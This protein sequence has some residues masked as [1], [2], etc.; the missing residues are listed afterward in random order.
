MTAQDGETTQGYTLTISRDPSRDASLADITVA[1]T[2]VVDNGD[3][4][5]TATLDEATT[6]SSVTVTAGNKFATVVI[7]DVRNRRV[8]GEG[9]ARASIT[10]DDPGDGTELRIKITAQ[11]GR[12]DDSADYTLTVNRS[13]STDARLSALELLPQSSVAVEPLVI[14][15]SL[16]DGGEYPASFTDIVTGVRVKP[17]AQP[18]VDKI[19][20]FAPGSDRGEVVAENGQSSLIAVTEGRTT[21]ITIVVTAQDRRTTQDYIVLIT[22]GNIDVDLGAL[23]IISGEN[24]LADFDSLATSTNYVYTIPNPIVGDKITSV[25]LQAQAEHPDATISLTVDDD[26]PPR[27]MG[28]NTI[29]ENIRLDEGETKRARIVVTAQRRSV[30]KTYTVTI[31][32][33]ASRD[34]RL[35]RLA[36]SSSELIP[37]FGFDSSAAT[38]EIRKYSVE[39]PNDAANVNLGAAAANANT[40]LT[41]SE[42]GNSRSGNSVTL[43]IAINPGQHEDIT[44]SATAQDRT[45]A[46][47]TVVISRAASVTRS[48]LG[49]MLRMSDVA[50]NPEGNTETEYRGELIG[51]ATEIIASAAATAAGV[52][53]RSI[54]LGGTEYILNDN[55]VDLSA[56]LASISRAIPLQRGANR[57]TLVVR[58]GDSTEDGY[59]EQSYTVTVIRP[60]VL[61]T[62][63]LDGLSDDDPYRFDAFTRNYTV[64][65]AN[66]SANLVV[67]PTL[68]SGDNGIVEYTI[69]DAETE[70]IQ[71]A[72]GSAII[73]FDVDQTKDITIAL[74]AP[75]ATTSNYVVRATR[76][77]SDNANLSALRIVSGGNKLADFGN[78][79]T[80]ADY[81]YTIPN[82]IVGDKI[83]SVGLETETEHSS[84]TITVAVDGA[85][86]D[87]SDAISFVDAEGETK[88]VSIKVLAED[89]QTSK[90]YTVAIDREQSRD[91]RLSMLRVSQG[92]LKPKF[93]FNMNSASQQNNYSVELPNNMSN[94]T[95]TAMAFAENTT[96]VIGDRSRNSGRA[97]RS[98]SLTVSVNPGTK[99][100]ITIVVTPQ[101]GDSRT[102]IVTLLR[103]SATNII[104]R[105]VIRIRAKVFLEGPLQ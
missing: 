98:A 38:Q 83:T 60:L 40:I 74:V 51:T 29:N 76:K 69:F 14:F 68:F 100:D 85:D 80:S 86:A 1:G 81:V 24:T 33:A 93:M 4:T 44:I 21:T 55:P 84:A 53:I 12:E 28:V 82:P 46:T 45:T 52:S 41:I 61:Q 7:T 59:T 5:Y 16:S 95:I 17:T 6:S 103:A 75:G 37:Q 72:N 102:Y 67:S 26:T 88:R 19:E 36:V 48:A 20:V 70:V 87:I 66:D 31:V 77:A 22:L 71:A 63:G 18:Y 43:P 50:L 42:V 79:A 30:R 34:T 2:S 99:K 78:L 32:R 104:E 65:I 39:L 35:S 101:S 3:G 96:L 97:S 13:P 64:T 91:T 49:F 47:Y 56:D 11:S 62:L 89:R 10:L 9:A 94:M 27:V 105:G 54:L 23:R 90:T 25:S 15:D 57:I 8:E 58:R 73:R 92:V